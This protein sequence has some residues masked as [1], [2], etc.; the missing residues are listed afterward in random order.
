MGGCGSDIIL[1]RQLTGLP[2]FSVRTSGAINISHII[3]KDVNACGGATWNAA[4]STNITSKYR[5]EHNTTCKQ[6]SRLYWI[7]NSGNCPI[8]CIGRSLSGGVPN[9]PAVMSRTI[10]NVFFDNNSFNII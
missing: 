10:N 9:A 5:M 1:H 7:G 8:L 4:N 6:R 3:I 2:Q